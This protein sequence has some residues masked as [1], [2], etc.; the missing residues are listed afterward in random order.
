MFA[1]LARP[2]FLFNADDGG[3]GGGDGSGSGEAAPP[4]ATPPAGDAGD[5]PGVKARIDGALAERD[6][7]RTRAE[8]AERK[9]AELQQEN[10]SASEKKEREAREATARA[11]QAEAKATRLERESWV[12]AAATEFADPGDVIAMV[13]LSANDTE[14]KVRNAVD[15][16]KADKPYLL[17]ENQPGRPA[18]FGHPG[19]EG[20]GSSETV[21]VGADGQPDEAL[22][23]GRDLLGGLFG[24]TR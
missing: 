6:R 15:K 1:R 23:L 21:P 2:L 13:D 10:E 12:R 18:G 5:S 9:L 8:E 4:P 11:E 16:L 14:T 7:E 24:K 19:G 20:G 3:G 22:G 17:R